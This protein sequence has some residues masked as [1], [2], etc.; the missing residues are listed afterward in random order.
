VVICDHNLGPGA[1][2]QQVLEEA[3]LR[4]LVGVSTIWVMVTAE[5]T[6]DMVM[7]AAEVKPDDYL[8]KPINQVLLQNRLEKLIARKQSLGVVEA[9]IKAK[10]FG[11]AVGHCDQ[12]LKDKTVSPQEILR[13]KSDLLLTMGDYAAARAVFE[14]V[15]T[16]RNIA[17]AKTG[18]GKVLYFT[19]DPAGAAALFEQVLR[20]NPMYVEAADWL[21]KA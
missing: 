13:I 15:L 19:Q 12:L 16:V 4:N 9:A 7:G 11:A 8:L 14:S 21:A 18:L 17:W 2:G 3:K 6:T 1:N 20:D 5:K 10:D